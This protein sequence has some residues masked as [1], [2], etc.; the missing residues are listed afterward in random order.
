MWFAGCEGAACLLLDVANSKAPVVNHDKGLC[1]AGLA[2]F[3]DELQADFAV[4]WLAWFRMMLMTALLAT[5]GLFG[6]M[7]AGE[8]LSQA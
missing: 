4:H 8:N 7:L 3:G 1:F 5:A 6:I 2:C